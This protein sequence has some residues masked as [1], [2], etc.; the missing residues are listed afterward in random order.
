MLVGVGAVGIAGSTGG[1]GAAG[2]TGGDG[3]AA[4][5]EG[6]GAIHVDGRQVPVESVGVDSVLEL[7]DGVGV[8]LGGGQLDGD[9]TT[10]GV[11]LPLLAV[12]ATAAVEGIHAAGVGRGGPE[13]DI[14]AHVVDELDTAGARVTGTVRQGSSGS[15]EDAGDEDVGEDHLE[16]GRVDLVTKG[17]YKFEKKKGLV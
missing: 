3:E 14:R 4:L 17:L 16:R 7:E 9:T 8:A 10:V 12:S 5:D 15:S 13:I 6:R 1:R 11:G 2:V